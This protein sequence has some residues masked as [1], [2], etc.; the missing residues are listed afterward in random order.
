MALTW[1]VSSI[2]TDS[3]IK[4]APQPIYDRDN[5]GDNPS[6][7]IGIIINTIASIPSESARSAEFKSRQSRRP[8]SRRSM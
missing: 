3:S 4:F 5:Q 7:F 6:L 2:T 8:V 1:Q